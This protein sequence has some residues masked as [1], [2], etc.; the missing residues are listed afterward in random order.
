M[1][2]LNII[3][4]LLLVALVAIPIFDAARAGDKGW[5]DWNFGLGLY[6]PLTTISGDVSM[7]TPSGGSAELPVDLRFRDIADNWKGGINGIFMLKKKRWSFNLDLGYVKLESK[8]TMPALVPE[9][10]EVTTTVTM[11]EHEGF[12]G[13]QISDPE[14]GVTEL[15]FGARYIGQDIT[16]KAETT[17]S[18]LSETGVDEEASESW[19]MGFIGARFFGPLAG[20]ESWKLLI[21]ADMGA[22]DT[23]GRLTWRADLGAD[24]QFA[25]H[26][27]LVVMYK[28]LGIDYKKG[29][30]GDSDYYYY[31][32]TEHGPVIGVGVRF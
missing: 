27:D 17:A 3:L 11:N 12:I 19:Y 15:I 22:F 28:W 16:L 13:Y 1:R 23:S 24:W 26:W 32:A 10:V 8:Q 20:S 6:L 31:K 4:A 18:T 14:A 25:K 5:E 29:E 21:R 30:P 2:S 9:T 7:A